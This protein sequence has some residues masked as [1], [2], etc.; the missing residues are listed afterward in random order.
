MKVD[1]QVAP[2]F[3]E[4]YLHQSLFLSKYKLNLV[5]Y[6]YILVALVDLVSYADL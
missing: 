3:L 2:D 4:G 1:L 5:S 6:G